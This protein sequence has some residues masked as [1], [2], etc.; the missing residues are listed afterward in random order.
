MNNKHQGPWS[1]VL[2]AGNGSRLK[3]LTTT[4]EGDTVPKQFCSLNR[5][6][7]LLQLA[8]QRAAV[9]SSPDQVGTVVA[10]QHRR[11]W[12]RP[13][14]VLP[15]GNIFVQPSNRGT[16]VG[17]AL[18]LLHVEKH[19]PDAIVVL[20]PAD[21]YVQ[22][23]WVLAESLRHLCAQASRY[24]SSVFLLG[25]EP[26][27][28]DIEMGYIVPS[29][30]ADAAPGASGVREFVEKPP[31]PRAQELLTHGALWNMFIVAGALPILLSFF[32][33]SYN[34][35]APMRAAMR[36]P[37]GSLS[38]LYSDLPIVDFSRDVLAHYPQHLKVLSVPPCGWT[39][40]GTPKRVAQIV[41]DSASNGR[42]VR[43]TRG[44]M[45]LDLAHAVG[46]Q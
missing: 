30:R 13:L 5:R 40:L 35:L 39:D 34:F 7:C 24:T 29:E 12:K 31:I 6:E 2:A 38:R 37:L 4:A 33:R 27:C 21:H 43:P 9:I 11:W 25:T 28:V 17:T 18:A 19:N 46:S 32:E 23:E 10:A 22:Q 42:Q 14:G 45:Y 1:I 8:L 44:A 3:E 16:A 41:H 20:L 26:D 36:E 15:P